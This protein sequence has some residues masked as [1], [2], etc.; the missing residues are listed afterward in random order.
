[1]ATIHY[2]PNTTS[3]MSHNGPRLPV[4]NRRI[5]PTDVSLYVSRSD[6]SV[7]EEYF[8]DKNVGFIRLYE[9]ANAEA[10]GKGLIV[11][12]TANSEQFQGTLT[13]PPNPKTYY[14]NPY[15]GF[16]FFNRAD[17]NT[18]ILVNYTARGSIIAAEEINW[19]WNICR[20][21]GQE[22][23]FEQTD[24]DKGDIVINGNTAKFL[25][26]KIVT[27]VFKKQD[28][29][30]LLMNPPEISVVI[31]DPETSDYYGTLLQNTSEQTVTVRVRWIPKM[32]PYV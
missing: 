18:K 17:L 16:L 19:L 7:V 14:Y 12:N 27:H 22:W 2:E 6:Y 31:R 20:R 26:Q 25:S 4:A 30:N 1:M 21:V 9:A 32:E 28:D 11:R 15:M 13:Y 29:G 5:R 8:G 23:T 3:N 24:N 10:G